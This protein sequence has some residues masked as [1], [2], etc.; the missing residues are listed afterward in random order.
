MRLNGLLALASLLITYASLIPS[1]LANTEKAIFVAPGAEEVPQHTARRSAWYLA[2]LPRLTHRE[3]TARV[4]LDRGFPN[5]T[6]PFGP[7][8][9]FLLEDLKPGKRYEARISWA[10]T[11]RAASPPPPRFIRHVAEVS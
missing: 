8:T 5:G 2:A 6:S 7:E 10:A 4:E 11:V 1:A 3:F 9:W